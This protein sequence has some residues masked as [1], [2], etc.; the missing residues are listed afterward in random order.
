MRCQAVLYW[1]LSLA[2]M[3][4]WQIKVCLVGFPS[5]PGSDW[6]PGWGGVDPTYMHVCTFEKFDGIDC[7]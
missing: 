3:Q 6:N 7:F 5:K 4:L 1:G 2:R